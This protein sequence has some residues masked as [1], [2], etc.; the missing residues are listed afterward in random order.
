MARSTFSLVSLDH[1]ANMEIA[2]QTVLDGTSKWSCKIACTGKWQLI[3]LWTVV[4]HFIFSA[5]TSE[6]V[7]PHFL[8][9]E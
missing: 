1:S 8:A 5:G 2:E 9:T 4:F 3:F 7:S 6:T